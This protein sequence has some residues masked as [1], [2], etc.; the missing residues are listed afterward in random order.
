MNACQLPPLVDIINYIS[1]PS[2]INETDID[3]LRECINLI[4]DEFITVNVE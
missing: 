3:E 2:N 4:I 1:V